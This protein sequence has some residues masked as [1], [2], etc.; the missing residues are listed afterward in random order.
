[1]KANLEARI[2]KVLEKL[3]EESISIT[4]NKPKHMLNVGDAQTRNV[5]GKFL[6]QTT[7]SEIVQLLGGTV[8]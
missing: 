1:M 6:S 7:Y 8:D 3:E 2:A 4:Y 5:Q